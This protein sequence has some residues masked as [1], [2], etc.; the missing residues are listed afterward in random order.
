MAVKGLTAIIHFSQLLKYYICT[1]TTINNNNN[2]N[3]LMQQF[4]V[5]VETQCP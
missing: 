1:A 3:V 4:C 2:N 5:Y